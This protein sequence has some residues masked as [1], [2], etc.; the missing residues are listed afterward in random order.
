MKK[1]FL[2]SVLSLIFTAASVMAQGTQKKANELSKIATLKIQSDLALDNKNMGKI[3]EIFETYYKAKAILTVGMPQSEIIEKDN[4]GGFD[5]INEKRN[6]ALKVLINTT[7]NVKWL[8]IA[9]TFTQS[10][11]E[12]N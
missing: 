6:E 11:V 4:L 3:Y 12:V 10:I 1:Y 9:K 8:Q 7:Q 5:A 2:L